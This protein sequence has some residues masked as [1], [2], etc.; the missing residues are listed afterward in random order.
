MGWMSV[1][2]PMLAATIVLGSLA[3]AAAAKPDAGDP[4]AGKAQATTCG[5]CHGPDGASPVD[6]TYPALAGQNERYLLRQLEAIQSKARDV[7]LMTGQLDGKSPQD[8]ADLAAYFASL[9]GAAGAADADDDTIDLAQRIYKGGIGN[10]G[11]P[12]CSAC[13][14]PTGD[15]NPPAGFP[16]ISGQSAGYVIAQLTAYREGRRTTDENYGGMMRGVA[17]HL[18]DTEIAALAEYVRGLH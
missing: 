17:S 5:A 7:P 13:H 12:A 14:A 3:H 2:R 10:K 8:L 16:D 11:V 4:A 9:P 6:P 1:A 15:G 18:T